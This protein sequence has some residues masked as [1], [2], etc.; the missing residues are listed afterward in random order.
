MKIH[1]S[2]IAPV[3]IVAFLGTILIGNAWELPSM[4]KQISESSDQV[5]TVNMIV[6]GLR[7]RG[8][9]NFFIKVVGEVPGIVSVTTYVQEH[10]A[11]IEYDPSQIDPEGIVRSVEKPIRLSDGSLVAPFKVLEIVD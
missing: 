4:Q 11:A 5:Q 1:S 7:C 3:V 2:L 6:D 10:R 8:T 9:S